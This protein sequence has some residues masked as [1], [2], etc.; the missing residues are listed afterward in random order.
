MWWQNHCK[1]AVVHEGR[2]VSWIATEKDA[3]FVA[4]KHAK[5]HKGQVYIMT[6]IAKVVA[7]PPTYTVQKLDVREV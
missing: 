3:V 2:L 1:F 6:P 4:H 5:K 7:D